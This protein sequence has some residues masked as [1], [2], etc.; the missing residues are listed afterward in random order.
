MTTAEAASLDVVRPSDPRYE[1]VRHVYCATGSPAAIVRVRDAGEVADALALALAGDGPFAIRSGGHGIS[2]IATNVGGTVIDLSRLNR[3]EV[4]GGRRVRVGPGARWR[5]VAS[6]LY[7]HG[8]AISSGD[9]GDVGVGG[10]A[11]AGGLGLLA[12]KYGLTIDRLVAAEI[13]TAD[14]ETHRVSAAREPELFWAIR[15]A[16]ANFGIVTA[17]EFDA[18][19]T[20]VVAHGSFAFTPKDVAGFVERWGR[21]VEQAPREISAFLYLGGSF[22]QASVVYAGQDSDAAAAALQPFTTLPD[23]SGGQARLVPYA[24]VL[25][26]TGA[27]HLG[28]QNARARTG[29]AVHLDRE[30]SRRIAHLAGTVDMVHIR[31][32]GGAINDLPAD[33]TAYAHRHQNFCVTALTGGRRGALD[34]AWERV[35]EYMDGIYLSFESAHGPSSVSEAFPE[36]TLGRLRALK[37]RWDPDHIFTQNFDITAGA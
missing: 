13:T 35:H 22:A 34:A 30:T 6:E 33:A 2:S 37:K 9:S 19:P 1:L 18:A 15:G 16:G 8:L 29:L 5:R 28:Q 20:P 23:I 4:L 26:T 14:G 3:V 11:T 12:R 32:A 17:F 27:P 36:P 25:P 31:S 21:T 24:A 10:L 7:P